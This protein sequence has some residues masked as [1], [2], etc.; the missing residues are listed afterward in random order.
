MVTSNVD[1][2]DWLQ[3]QSND[4]IHFWLELN[5]LISSWFGTNQLCPKFSHIVWF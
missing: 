3:L 2:C 5:D 1:D 4:G